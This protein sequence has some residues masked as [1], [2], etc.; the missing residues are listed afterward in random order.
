MV[1]SPPYMQDEGE[2]DDNGKPQAGLSVPKFGKNPSVATEF[3]PDRW[4]NNS[5]TTAAKTGNS[6]SPINAA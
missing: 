2:E 1:Y 4:V 6:V 5:G 3:L